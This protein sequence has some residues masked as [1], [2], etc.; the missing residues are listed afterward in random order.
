MRK[1]TLL[2][3][4]GL[5]TLSATAFA[6][7]PAAQQAVLDIY[8]KQAGVQSF[9][10][11]AGKAFFE[12]T[13]TGGHPD[14]TSCTDCHTKNPKNQGRTRAGKTIAPVAVSVNPQ[15]FTDF[16][17]VEKWFHRNCVSVLGRDCTATEK[18]NYIAYMSS[19]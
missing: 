6:A 7:V 8:A 2:A 11:A 4:A 16:K 15:R 19:I 5:L 13:F 9:D 14:T 18:G 10:P 12:G 3:A 1:T 17:K